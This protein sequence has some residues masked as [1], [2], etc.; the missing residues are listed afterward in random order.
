MAAAAAIWSC[1]DVTVHCWHS[2]GSDV[3]IAMRIGT[4][5]ATGL[6]RRLWVD[7][8]ALLE[9][10]RPPRTSERI[11]VLNYCLSLDF[12]FG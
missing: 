8:V 7:T 1:V 5:L 3:A 9:L 2:C 10:E 12:G 11:N 6:S 4:R